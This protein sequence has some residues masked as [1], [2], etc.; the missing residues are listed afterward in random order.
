MALILE[1]KKIN[2]QKALPHLQVPNYEFFRSEWFQQN[3]NKSD[4]G[5]YI[6]IVLNAFKE[7]PFLGYGINSFP[8]LN[9]ETDIHG[10]TIRYPDPHNTFL[11]ILY[12]YGLI[13]LIFFLYLILKRHFS[14]FKKKIVFDL[15][16]INFTIILSFS[17][18]FINLFYVFFLWFFLSL[19]FK[20]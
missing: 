3:K 5:R 15:S 11:L 9:K 6:F 12:E 16:M 7:R 18:F 2:F 19:K 8:T 1:R 13:G 10:N 4:R 20:R 17:L 14:F